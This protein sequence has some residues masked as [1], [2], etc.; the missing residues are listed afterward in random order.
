MPKKE[1]TKCWEGM[2]ELI[3]CYKT[4]VKDLPCFMVFTIKNGVFLPPDD[5]HYSIFN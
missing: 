2:A 5:S 3:F 1:R 4:E